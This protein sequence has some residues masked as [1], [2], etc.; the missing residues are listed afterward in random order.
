M[1]GMY[2]YIRWTNHLYQFLNDVSQT[3]IHT[4]ESLVPEPSAFEVGIAIDK[5]KSIN[6]WVFIKFQ[7]H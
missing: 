6:H 2:K 3:E 7:Q 4:T 5:L 1:F